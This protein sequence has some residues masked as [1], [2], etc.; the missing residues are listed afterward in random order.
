M[1]RI[2]NVQPRNEAPDTIPEG[3]SVLGV[4]SHVVEVSVIL[5]DRAKQY[6]DHLT[7]EEF[8]QTCSLLGFE[9]EPVLNM[10]MD[11]DLFEEVFSDGD[12][13]LRPTKLAESLV[14]KARS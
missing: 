3:T 10:C 11:I 1:N 5:V 13:V 7:R 14:E 9:G 4:M 8:L 6:D 2:K 12:T